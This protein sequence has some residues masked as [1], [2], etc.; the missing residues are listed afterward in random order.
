MIAMN[1]PT[2]LTVPWVRAQTLLTNAKRPTEKRGAVEMAKEKR[3]AV[4]RAKEGR[5]AVNRA[6][7]ERRAVNRAKEMRKAARTE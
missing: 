4:R 3:G 6:K 5:K 1:L 7:E 2:S